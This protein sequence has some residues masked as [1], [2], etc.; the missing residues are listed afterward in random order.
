MNTRTITE[1]T[2]DTIISCRFVTFYPQNLCVYG[3]FLFAVEPPI[4][5]APKMTKSRI[6]VGLLV[7]D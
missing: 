7:L 1:P 2:V 4:E 5:N 6:I 3:D